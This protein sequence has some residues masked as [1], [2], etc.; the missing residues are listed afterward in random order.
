MKKFTICILFLTISLI[1][2][3]AQTGTIKGIV[4]DKETN[5]PLF[6]ANLIINH[7]SYY[8]ITNKSGEFLI[9]GIPQGKYYLTISFVGY[10]TLVKEINV[11]QNET[12]ILDAKLS[13][14]PIHLGEVLVTSTKK[15]NIVREISLHIEV[16]TK[17]KLEEI[18]S[19]TISDALTN[20]PG[21][22]LSR[23]GI[24]ATH[25]N[26][27]GLSKQ[28][29]V[30]LIDGNRIETATNIAAGMS[31]IDLDDV[32][33]IEVIKGGVSSL[34]GTGATGGVVN[35]Q[36]F[37]PAYSDALNISGALSSSYNSVNEGAKVN[38]SL[39]ASQSNWFA[40]FN[41]TLRNAADTETPEGTLENSQFK[42]NNISAAIGFRPFVNH[43][44]KI[45]YQRFSAK[46]VGIPGG[47]P[48]PATAKATYPTELRE[49]YSVEYQLQNLFPSLMTLSAKYFH[50][51]IE[52]RVEII[53]NPNAITNT[54]ADHNIDGFQ[55]QTDWYISNTNRL[56]AGIDYWQREY[57]GS[58]TRY[59]KPQNRYIIDSPVPNSTYKS[60]GI[61]AQDEFILFNNR[62][63]LTL[64]GRYDFINVS[65]EETNN[66]NYI[67]VDGN[68]NDNPPIIPEASYLK[69]EDDD[70]SWSANIGLL[71]KATKNIDFTLNL[72]R[73]F[74]SPTLEERY[75]YIDLGGTVY[76]GNPNLE[77]EKS[78]S[79][80]FGVRYWSDLVSVKAN[81]FYNTFNDLV[82]DQYDLSDSL[83]RTQ[84]IGAAEL[85][86]FELSTEVNPYKKVAMYA[87]TSY[88]RGKDTGNDTDLA[89]I[90]PLNGVIGIKT[91]VSNLFNIDVNLRYSAKQNKV[92]LEE[93]ITAGYG[94]L[95]LFVNSFPINLGS[96]D[97]QIFAGIE[98]VFDKAY[99]NHLST[100]RGLVA[101]EPGRNIFAKIKL[102]W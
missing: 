102:S 18:P 97:L 64:G 41:G 35:I 7:T 70:K 92:A 63:N 20:K 33:R 40:K 62:L 22:N 32:E 17:S 5:Q 60:L 94:V 4:S 54:G 6:S 23:D 93:K 100:Y 67:I 21:V 85:Y 59:I 10:Q 53:P 52:R 38:L 31:L 89:E 28:N 1:S 80:D 58:R 26:I 68:R 30:T 72:A 11:E 101:L 90:P 51:L 71:F 57:D 12:I 86:G 79:I 8:G 84:N 47:D 19:T 78:Y 69:N 14:T 81:V 43:Q 15:G 27:R 29:V 98:N 39:S 9:E 82:A 50:Q 76:L 42:D 45:N 36:S 75:Q 66:P 48:F 16:V 2:L 44:L 95:N 74:R 65:N 3:I 24:W 73:A 55:F 96:V 91:P 25:V 56:I 87:N 46:D 77:P 99:R 37:T 88:V 61:F 49:M 13:S 83:Y 34:Y